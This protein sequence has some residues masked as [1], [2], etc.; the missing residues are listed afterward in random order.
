[1]ACTVS[2]LWQFSWPQ[3]MT[4]LPPFP[5]RNRVKSVLALRG[6]PEHSAKTAMGNRIQLPDFISVCYSV[7]KETREKTAHL[8]IENCWFLITDSLRR[9]CL[10]KIKI[11]LFQ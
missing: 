7:L 11:C 9:T 4:L 8:L 6:L 3:V 5:G 1:M 10:D 2:E